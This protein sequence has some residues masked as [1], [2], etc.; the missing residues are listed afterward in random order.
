[1]LYHLHAPLAPYPLLHFGAEFVNFVFAYQAMQAQAPSEGLHTGEENPDHSSVMSQIEVQK[2]AL[3]FQGSSLQCSKHPQ[4]HLMEDAI[5]ELDHHAEFVCMEEGSWEG[6][7]EAVAGV[8]HGIA[9]EGD[10][11]GWGDWTGVFRH[12]YQDWAHHTAIQVISFIPSTYNK[13]LDSL[14][15]SRMRRCI[16]LAWH[17]APSPAIP[18]LPILCFGVNSVE[19]IRGHPASA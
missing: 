10:N 18:S 7:S 8:H 13:K 9:W 16:A 14:Q 11:C 19:E 1:M 12:P 3:T 6:Y 15:G 4:K 2:K 17:P 5:C